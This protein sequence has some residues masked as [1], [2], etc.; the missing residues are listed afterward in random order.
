MYSHSLLLVLLMFALLGIVRPAGAEVRV[1]H[2]HMEV[3]ALPSL[4]QHP[5]QPYINWNPGPAYDDSVRMFQGIPSIAVAPGGKRLW[6]TWYGGGTGE[7]PHNYILL[8]TSG[9]GGATWSKVLATIDPPCRASEPAVWV[10]PDGV[11]WWMWNQYPHGLTSPG[12]QLWVMTTRN[13][14]DETPTWDSP[15]LI[16]T[17]MNNFNKPTVLRDGTWLWPTGSW[18]WRTERWEGA[19]RALGHLSRPMFS[20]DGGQ[21]F[22]YGG[23]IPTPIELNA[24]DEYQVVER[25][26]GVLWLMNRM[27]QY[28]IGQSFSHDGGQTWS[29]FESSGIEHTTSR[30]FFGRLQSGNLLL[31][32]NG[33]LDENVGRSQ[34][35]AFLSQDDG[36]TWTGGLML[37]ERD[38]VSYPDADQAPDGTIH[39]IYDRARHHD[40]EI[41]LATFTEADVLAGEPVS[42]QARFKVIINKATGINPRERAE[43]I[44]EVPLIRGA[45]PDLDTGAH[46]VLM[47]EPGAKLFT[48]RTHSWNEI[49]SALEGRRFVQMSIDGGS[50]TVE[51][52]GVLY[53]A[54]PTPARNRDS[55][56]AQLARQGFSMV[57]DI[58]EFS[59]FQHAQHD[60]TLCRLFQKEVAA[61][62]RIQIGKW[63]VIIF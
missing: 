17:E 2:P 9:D 52:P 20:R 48:D 47:V 62:D 44:S 61:G 22:Y 6:A 60:A 37:D 58:P 40:K 10:D 46:T 15:R 59:L 50:V 19:Q 25:E 54:T 14:D 32:K 3:D 5:H 8:A 42:D 27:R 55:V 38:R 23:E 31:V 45:A 51:S 34:M 33:P 4:L 26:D 39:V 56:Q 29:E 49:P 7:G 41:L 21:T 63:G 28:G 12:S 30:F 43:T 13:P 36:A 53:V 16:A 57:S 24:F 35:M 11:L 1:W 18:Q